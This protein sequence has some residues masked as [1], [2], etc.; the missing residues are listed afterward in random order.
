MK[1]VSVNLCS[2]AGR[3][4]FTLVELMVAMSIGVILAGTVV[5]LLVQAATEERHGYSDMTVEERAYTL[6]AN[7]TSCLRGSSAGL[8]MTPNN[9]SQVLSGGYI[10]GYTSIYVFKPNANGSAFT[11]AQISADL[12]SGAVV[13]TPDT[14][15]PANQILWMTNSPGVVLR[16]LYF[17]YSGNLDGSQ[18]NQLVNVT[19]QMDDNGYSQ[20]NATNNVANIQRSFSVQ[21]RCD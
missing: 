15:V 13:Y 1:P 12:I 6:Q 2:N 10:I 17:M 19:F 18:N 9:G 7:I 3:R 14:S 8:G 16:Q 5:L 20:Q 4:A 11:T 21:M